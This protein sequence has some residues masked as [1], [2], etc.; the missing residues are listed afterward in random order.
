MPAPRSASAASPFLF[1]VLAACGGSASPPPETGAEP[2]P[3]AEAMA[4]EHAHDTPVASPATEPE[5]AVAVHAEEVSYAP[6]ARG[7]LARPRDV[8]PSRPRE[9]SGGGS[10]G[11]IVIHEWWGLYD[12]IR[13]ITRRLAGEGYLALAVDLYG[14][15][16]ASD[17]A[18]ARTLMERA[19]ADEPAARANLAAAAEYL[20]SQRVRRIGVIGW[21]F[22]GAW[23]LKTALHNPARIDAA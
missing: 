10:A 11:L 4:R 16:A 14:G 3:P 22:G 15:Q 18:G 19:N 5:P 2:E 1:L 13:A 6:N 21:C 20:A 12:Q 17:P 8:P 7:Y 23:S 9:G